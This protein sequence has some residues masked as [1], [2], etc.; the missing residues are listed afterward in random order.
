MSERAWHFYLEDMIR[1][2]QRVL[3]YADGLDQQLFVA[4]AMT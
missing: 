3:S 2:T 4:S 1:F